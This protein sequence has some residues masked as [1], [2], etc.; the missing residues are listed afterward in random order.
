MY[1]NI[2][3]LGW[4][5]GTA[6]S[7]SKYGFRSFSG[8]FDWYYSSLSGVVQCI[9]SDFK[10]FLKFENLFKIPGNPKE[11]E[12][13]K[14]KFHFMHEIETS[15]EKDYNTIYQKYIRRIHNF[16]MAMKEGSVCIRAVRNVEEID[17]ILN[18]AFY[19]EQIIKRMNNSNEL[20]LLFLNSFKAV[21]KVP[22]RYFVLN[23][24]RWGGGKFVYII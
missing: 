18:N 22:F 16:R 10:D 15:L 20:V 9:D 17:Y 19:I 4:F 3:S 8:P 11:F 2:I 5:C 23:I 7:L 6:A 1:R 12:D 21:C 14:Y 24:D 13:T